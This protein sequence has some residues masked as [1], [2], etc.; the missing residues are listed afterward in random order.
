MLKAFLI[1]LV[2]VAVSV[3]LLSIGI[4]VRGRFPNMHVSGNKA[5]REKGILCV[6]GQDREARLRGSIRQRHLKQQQ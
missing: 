2:I 1:T 5:L 3:C 4:M 6:Q